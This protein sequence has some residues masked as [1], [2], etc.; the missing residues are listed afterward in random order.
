MN[1][2]AGKVLEYIANKLKIDVTEIPDGGYLRGNSDSLIS[3]I[4]VM[5]KL[6]FERVEQ[7]LHDG[8]DFVIFH[9][10]PYWNENIDSELY[11]MPGIY[12]APEHWNAH[13]DT[14]LKKIIENSNAV[15]LQIHYGLDRLC[16]YDDFAAFLNFGRIVAG[17]RY[18]CIYELSKTYTLKELAGKIGN[19]LGMKQLRIIGNPDKAVTKIGNCWGGVGLSVNAY[20]IRRAYEL[21][22]DV[23]VA[24]ETDEMTMNFALS[25]GGAIIETGH[26]IS[27]NIGLRHFV[28]ILNNEI[29]Q[30]PTLKINYY[31][32]EKPYT[33]LNLE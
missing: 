20:F 7:A 21:G 24:G 30:D 15:F 3:N 1:N 12:H 31:S 9:E 19:A 33:I 28:E 2:K 10:W 14:K 23:I 22:A 25:C 17:A 5:W 11:R 13:P 8:A 16:I 27:E 26:F 4:A 29:Y 18:E 32:C 6:N